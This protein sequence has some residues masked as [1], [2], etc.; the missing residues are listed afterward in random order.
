VGTCGCNKDFGFNEGER[1]WHEDWIGGMALLH[2]HFG[3]LTAVALPR[4]FWRTDS[5]SKESRKMVSGTQVGT[6]EGKVR[7]SSAQGVTVFPY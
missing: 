2:L 6:Y 3:S 7:G 1:R 5:R 4:T